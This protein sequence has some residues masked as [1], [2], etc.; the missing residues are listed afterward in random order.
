MR[1]CVLEHG[2]DQ[3]TIRPSLSALGGPLLGLVLLGGADLY[4]LFMLCTQRATLPTP[5][6]AELVCIA[7][8]NIALLY[9]LVLWIRT[10]ARPLLLDRAKGRVVDGDQH[11]KLMG[12]T[13][14]F[15][16]RVPS[17]EG[18][19][20]FRLELAYSDGRLRLLGRSGWKQETNRLHALACGAEIAEFLRLPFHDVSNE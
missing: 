14:V 8:V 17:S 9:S 12:T 13:A 16:R 1:G 4:A 10:S 3:L 20:T 18:A 11:T 7:G 19:D 5:P 15:L 6:P 2:G